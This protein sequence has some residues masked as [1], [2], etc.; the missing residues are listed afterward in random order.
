MFFAAIEPFKESQLSEGILK[1]ML[2]QDIIHMLKV[3]EPEAQ[4]NFL[5]VQGKAV[6]YFILILEGHVEVT[7]GKEN[8]TFESGPFTYFGLAALQHLPIGSFIIF[9]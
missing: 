3:K 4:E 7:I 9:L 2:N 6:D 1:R 5:F 8:L